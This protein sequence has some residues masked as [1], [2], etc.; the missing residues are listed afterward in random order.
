MIPKNITEAMEELERVVTYFF[1]RLYPKTPTIKRGGDLGENEKV[2]SDLHLEIDGW[3]YITPFHTIETYKCI[4]GERTR[5]AIH[6]SIQREEIC[7][8][9]YR[10]ADGSGE[11]DT[12][13]IVN[14]DTGTL[15][16]SPHQAMVFVAKMILDNE[17]SNIG[18]VWGDEQMANA[19]EEYI[20]EM[21]Q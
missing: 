4:K 20:R 16:T 6:Y 15:L 21:Q 9:V 7:R 10:R 5:P 3:I 12:V 8:G 19:E 2:D 18:E 13:D 1:E 17:I 11:P 14:V